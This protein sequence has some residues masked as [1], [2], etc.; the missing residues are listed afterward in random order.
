MDYVGWKTN[1][2]LSTTFRKA[3]FNFPCTVNAM[4]KLNN[5]AGI[6]LN[7]DYMDVSAIFFSTPIPYTE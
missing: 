5:S 6:H 3:S 2:K 4:R 7:Y 1:E